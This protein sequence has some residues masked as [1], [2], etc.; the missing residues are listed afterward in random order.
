[1]GG[2][3]MLANDSRACTDCSA[4]DPVAARKRVCPGCGGAGHTAF[5]QSAQVHAETSFQQYTLNC[6]FEDLYDCLP[7]GK[8]RTGGTL[9]YDADTQAQV[10]TKK[11]NFF[12]AFRF[13]QSYPHLANE[14]EVN[15]LLD[16][17]SG[18]FY[19]QAVLHLCPH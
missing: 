19:E 9:I 6:A 18:Y 7:S 15:R 1:M 8:G 10:D 4:G 17:S 5:P 11:K 3:K 14:L 2:R 12:T 16:C 13:I